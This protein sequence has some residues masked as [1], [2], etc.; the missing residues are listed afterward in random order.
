MAALADVGQPVRVMYKLTFEKGSLSGNS[1]DVTV[2]KITLGRER[3]CHV[4]LKDEGISRVHCAIEQR[5][6][7]IYVLDLGATNGVRINKRRLQWMEQRL[8]PGDRVAIGSVE[9]RVEASASAAATK[10]DVAAKPVEAA[11]V[12]PIGRA[13]DTEAAKNSKRQ[14]K[15][16]AVTARSEAVG[17]ASSS[18]KQSD[19]K[20]AAARV[21]P[22]ALFARFSAAHRA[23]RRWDWRWLWWWCCIGWR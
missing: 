11:A 8:E 2:P 18:D 19:K 12:S 6:D 20:S 9:F 7:G 13:P 23:Q 17:S 4:R 16:V 1:L 5:A 3:D 14:D 21:A 10:K 22:L 15:P